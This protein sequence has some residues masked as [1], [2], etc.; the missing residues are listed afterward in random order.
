[1]AR[2]T[3]ETDR[4]WRDYCAAAGATGD[5]VIVS[6]GD[7][8]EM[9]DE[10]ADLVLNGPKRA[11]TSLLRDYESGA[12]PLPKIGDHV[13]VL[14]GDGR[15]K[16]IW[17]TVRVELRPF[18]QTDAAFAWDEGEGDRSLAYWLAAHRDFFTRQAAREGFEFT[19]DMGVVLERFR[20]VW[21]ADRR[22]L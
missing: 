17:R 3:P 10:L 6:F 1:M 15:P 12:E 9:A 19:E 22:D 4:Y 2:K 7:S 18:N 8:P 11:T 13:L 5:Y 21:P 14:G 16:L 20:L